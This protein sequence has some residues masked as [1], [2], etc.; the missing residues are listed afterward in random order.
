MDIKFSKD[1][2]DNFLNKL[3]VEYDVFAPI[4][5]KN[6]GRYSNVDSIRYGKIDSFNDVVYDRRS[7]YSAKEVLLPINHL[8]AVKINGNI[9]KN[10]DKDNE[11]K[12]III[13]RA[14]DIH[15]MERIDKKFMKDDYY[16]ARRENVKFM[17]MECPKAFDT[18]YCVSTKTNET[19][20]YSMGIR[21]DGDSIF[22]KVKDA[23]FDKYVMDENEKEDFEI[24]FAK[25]DGVNVKLP[26][27]EVWD[28]KALDKARNLEFWNEYK[29]RCIGCG[30][31]NASCPTCTCLSTKEVKINNSDVTEVR[32]VW[33][34][35]QL[36]KTKSL[37][38]FTVKDLVPARVRQ[39]VFDKFY[40]PKTEHSEEQLCVGCGR[41]TSICPKLISFANTL[42]RLTE[43]LEK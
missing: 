24:R 4:A 32:R 37:K 42:T 33:N 41:C 12:K 17:V 36:I 43:E 31:C 21:F 30:S 25:E 26:K 19:D 38:G 2:V 6:E 14:C 40:N 9:I 35:C 23:D 39:R 28:Y 16:K 29:N 20:N 13:L 18:C 22:I 5:Y 34:G 1:N 7:D 8:Y 10:E 15:A 11:K 3:R 27:F